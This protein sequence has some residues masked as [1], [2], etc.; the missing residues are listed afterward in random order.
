MT[1]ALLSA[2]A[3]FLFGYLVAYVIGGD[4]IYWWLILKLGI[5]G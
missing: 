5:L 2:G 4:P 1:R 3:G